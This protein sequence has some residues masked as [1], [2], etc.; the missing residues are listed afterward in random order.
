MSNSDHSP[1]VGRDAQFG[2]ATKAGPDNTRHPSRASDATTAGR[3]TALIPPERR[4]WWTWLPTGLLIVVSLVVT[5]LYA[6]ALTTAI[7][8]HH[9]A[10]ALDAQRDAVP[11]L[12]GWAAVA[13]VFY[14]GGKVAAKRA[15]SVEGDPV[16]QK[17]RQV[18]ADR[19]SVISAE[20]R[21]A[22]LTERL[23]EL[24]M[25]REEQ[26]SAA[27]T[28]L[29]RQITDTSAR[30]DRALLWLSRAQA[31]LAASQHQA[32]DAQTRLRADYPRRV[33]QQ[34]DGTAPGGPALP[35]AT[36]LRRCA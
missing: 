19:A 17:Q 31:A 33:P 6:A 18:A 36:A 30:L 32:A 29:D 16:S 22:T 20:R 10:A 3:H 27:D 14:S 25:T 35:G 34:P 13:I 5:V 24:T 15:R 2:R 8:Q 26:G 11:V 4:P 7:S 23:D 1:L 28:V 9:W 21:V 12:V